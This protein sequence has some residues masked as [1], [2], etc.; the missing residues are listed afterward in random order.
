MPLAPTPMSEAEPQS[1]PPLDWHHAIDEISAGGLEMKRVATE[2]ERAAVAAALG[3]LG[4]E[5]L[6]AKYRIKRAPADGYRLK[7]KVRVDVLQA[8]I[9]TL[10]PVLETV[11]ID[12]TVEFRPV[13]EQ[14]DAMGGS[15][16]LD[17]ETEIEPIEGKVLAVGRI[18]YEELA[19]GLNPYPRRPGAEFAPA[20]EISDDTKE[21]PFAVLAKLKAKP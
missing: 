19:A 12:L 1:A 14:K 8:C 9:V 6:E 2:A 10:A 5:S 4:C 18:V 15:V 20:A 7:G 13:E 16:D 3:I 17:E 11:V 21:N